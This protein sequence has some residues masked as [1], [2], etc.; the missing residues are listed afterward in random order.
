MPMLRLLVLALLL[1]NTAYFAWTQGLLADYG[2]A[3]ITQSEPQRLAQQ[4]RPEAMRLLAASQA[5]QSDGGPPPAKAAPAVVSIG[6]AQCLQA[7]PFNEQQASALRPRLE[8]SL[9]A[10]SWTLES[11]VAP[12][13]WIVYMGKYGNEEAL[14]KK[15]AELRQLGLAVEPLINPALGPGLSLGHFSAQIDA[16]RELAKAVSRGVRTARVVLEQPEVRGQLLRL[17]SVDAS[18]KA[19]LEALKPQLEGRTLEVC[20]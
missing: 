3:P 19:Q 18:L 14:A 15:R 17:P 5:R 16:E 6:A 4:I 9:P 10:G 13:R 2:F 20:R 12:G 1:A 8:S 7:G 11:S